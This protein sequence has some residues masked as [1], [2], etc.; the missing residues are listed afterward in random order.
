MK[1]LETAL[2][3]SAAAGD[4][5]A[6]NLDIEQMSLLTG[7]S[8]TRLAGLLANLEARGLIESFECNQ[9]VRYRLKVTH[10]RL[11]N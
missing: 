2:D 6:I 7:L 9:T 5:Q 11:N 1:N 3:N 10:E 4:N 8:P